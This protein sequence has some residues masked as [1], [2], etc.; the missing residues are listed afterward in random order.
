MAQDLRTKL[1]DLFEGLASEHGLELVMVELAGAKGNPLVRIYLDRPGGIGIDDI[2]SANTWVKAE[3]DAMP[4]FARGYSL[5]LSSPGIE[6]P[7]CKRAD[8]ERF[9]GQEASVSTSAEIDG[10]RRF[11]GTLGG[12]EGQ[13]VLLVA[14]GT[15][16]RIPLA[17]ITK[18]RLRPEIDFGNERKADDGL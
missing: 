2:A 12:V 3:L 8:L 7:L 4:E 16:I 15:T 13:D 9:A 14:G 5:E 17:A 1:T 6:R 18:A 10:R 11:T